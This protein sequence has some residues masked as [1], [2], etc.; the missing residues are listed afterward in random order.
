[1]PVT[2]RTLARSLQLSPAT[3]SNA[4]S[5]HGRISPATEQ[6]VK[7]AAAAAGYRRNPLA[8]SLMAEHRRSRGGAFRGVLAAIDIAE[9]SREPHGLFHLELVRGARTRALA[10]GFKLEQ[11]VVGRAG[12][13]MPRLDMILH[14]RGIHGIVLL[15]TWFPPDYSQ[16]DWSDY[17]GVY[18]D[19]NIQHPALHCV[20]CNHYR[21][22]MEVLEQLAARGYRRPGLFL[23][24]GRNERLQHR[25][26]AAFLAFQHTHP[27]IEIVP[28]KLASSVSAA[29]FIP[30]FKQHRPDV[31]ISHFT[32]PLDWMESCGARV[33]ARHGY[34][35]LNLLFKQRLSAGLDQQPR[36]LGTRATELVIAQL[37]RNERGLP[38]W[39][40]VTTTPARWVEGPTVRPLPTIR[41]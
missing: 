31:V 15:P 6:R 3:V 38:E 19:Y 26:G 28:L 27:G 1:M 13:T 4:L 29:E 11:F 39:P 2:V 7:Q 14:A 9:P 35:C 17:A 21:S 24:A 36:Q 22:M 20:C 41:A 34:V 32:T 23:E 16:L 5:G 30:W 33:P 18:T 25:W 40:T 8:G 10:L 37:Q 12:L